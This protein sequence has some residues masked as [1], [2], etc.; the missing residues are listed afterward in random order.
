MRAQRGASVQGSHALRETNKDQAQLSIA[1]QQNIL[2]ALV[3][4]LKDVGDSLQLYV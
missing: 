2:R 1:G 3:L 4:L